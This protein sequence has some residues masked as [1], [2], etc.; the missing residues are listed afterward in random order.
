[1]T[2]FTPSVTLQFLRE[3]DC[4][5]WD[6][7]L[8]PNSYF[9]WHGSHLMAYHSQSILR[10]NTFWNGFGRCLWPGS[11]LL[12]H[13]RSLEKHYYKPKMMSQTN[14][15]AIEISFVTIRGYSVK[16]LSWSAGER[17]QHQQVVCIS[18]NWGFTMKIFKPATLLYSWGAQPTCNGSSA[19]RQGSNDWITNNWIT[20][21]L[22]TNHWIT[23][24]WI[25]NHWI[26]SQRTELQ[27]K[28]LNCDSNDWIAIQVTELQ[29]VKQQTTSHCSP[30]P[31]ITTS[32]GAQSFC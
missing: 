2:H 10:I 9:G 3:T 21:H 8:W 17:G 16:G 28:W 14:K 12:S 6:A 7:R 31:L 4:R 1:M 26:T 27:V 15:T 29:L 22:I 32:Y 11:L 5:D 20:N 13:C 24:H 23:N 18:L 30:S 25:T 19:R